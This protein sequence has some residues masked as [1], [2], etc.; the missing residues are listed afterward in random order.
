M[1]NNQDP[2]D[3]I[4]PNAK[5]FVL[6]DKL[7]GNFEDIYPENTGIESLSG[8]LNN[9]LKSEMSPPLPPDNLSE[10]YVNESLTSLIPPMA[11]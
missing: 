8:F 3:L 7:D 1:D 10:T 6:Y 11:T 5:D 2:I 9:V 4:K